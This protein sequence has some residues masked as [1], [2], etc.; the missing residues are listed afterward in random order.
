MAELSPLQARAYTLPGTMD[1]PVTHPPR[2]LRLLLL[3]ALVLAP[4]ASPPTAQISKQKSTLSRMDSGFD[5]IHKV[6][7]AVLEGDP[8]LARAEAAQ[9]LAPAASSLPAALPPPSMRLRYAVTSSQFPYAA[10]GELVWQHDASSYSARLEISILMF[11]RVQTSQGA[12]SA[13]GLEPQRFGDKVRS[14]VTAHFERAKGKVR[15]SANTPDVPLQPGAQDQLSVFLQLAA[16]LAAAPQNYPEGSTL[17]FQAIGPR[18]AE[19]WVFTVGALESL[20]LPGG[21]ISALRL[22]RPPAAQNAPS[23][24]IW[25]AP[26]LGYMPVRILLRQGNGDTVDQRWSATEQP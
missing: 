12:L 19:D 14:E 26:A 21:T 1:S 3:A 23:G 15:F 11:A 22:T 6:V 20:H 25:L 18:S 4:L 16:L 2:I 9:G 5:A 8:L 17:A 13:Q 24:E 7:N 10:Q